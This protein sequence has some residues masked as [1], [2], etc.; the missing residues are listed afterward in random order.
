MN[1]EYW[2]P[3]YLKI[4]NSYGLSVEKWKQSTGGTRPDYLPNRLN[5]NDSSHLLK[6]DLELEYM[7]DMFSKPGCIRTDH[8]I[9]NIC[10]M[11]YFEVTILCKGDEWYL[12]T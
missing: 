5:V 2:L 11:Y 12:P 4:N 9:P 1:D 7:A 3:D 6:G 10:Q 8:P